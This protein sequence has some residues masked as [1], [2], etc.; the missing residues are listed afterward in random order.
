MHIMAQGGSTEPNTG[1]T[2]MGDDAKFDSSADTPTLHTPG[3]W[4]DIPP[5]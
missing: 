4:V 3:T 5:L 2:V 1:M